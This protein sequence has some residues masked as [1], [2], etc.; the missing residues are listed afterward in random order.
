MEVNQFDCLGGVDILSFEQE[1]KLRTK[2]YTKE[3]SSIKSE[4]I[5]SNTHSMDGK[6]LMFNSIIF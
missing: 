6:Y 3:A 4:S 1:Q 5:L 2:S